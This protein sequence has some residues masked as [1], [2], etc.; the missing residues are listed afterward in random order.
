R[1]SAGTVSTKA[2]ETGHASGH[3]AGV[4]K[5]ESEMEEMLGTMHGL[6]DMARVERHKIVSGAEPEIVRLAMGIAER[7][8]H[9]AVE[10]DRDIVI[11]MTKA[12][13]AQLVDRES[14]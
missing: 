11:A 13:I 14:I 9:K 5:A 4:A 10:V 3:A 6:I 12:A 2:Q 1:Q 8:I 7:V